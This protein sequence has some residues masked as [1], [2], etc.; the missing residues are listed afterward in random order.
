VPSGATQLTA[1]VGAPIRH[2]LSPTIFN[3]AFAE[4]GLDWTMVAFEVDAER[5]PAALAGAQALGIRAF[6]VTMPL[7]A[8]LAPL[9][10]MSPA[11]ATLG[12]V[13]SVRIG[14]TPEGDNTDGAGLLDAL[15]VDVG[16]VPADQRCVVLG[17]GGAARSVIAA[18]AGAGASVVVVNRTPEA[19]HAAA[20]LGATVGTVADVAGADL[21]VNATSVGMAGTAA[22]GSLPLDPAALRKDQVVVDLVYNPI[23][24]P[25]LEA[26]GER[27]AT[28]VGGL[29]MLV[30]QAARQ[31]RWWTGTD[32]PIAV[33]RD[34]AMARLQHR[35]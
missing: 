29:G 1:V 10:A 16:F 25:L 9:V 11:A 23:R 7:K 19:A 21:V 12:V 27:G 35:G 4:S 15:A 34:A 3:A 8:V 6:S 14:P 13:N 30:H 2:S 26:A 17:A 5:G 28:A 18:L 22:A 31:F 24:T 33:M 32:A 20:A